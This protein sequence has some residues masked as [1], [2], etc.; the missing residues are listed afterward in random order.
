[1]ECSRE[2]YRKREVEARELERTGSD[3]EKYIF[4]FVILIHKQHATARYI[5]Q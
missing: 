3:K 2:R 4:C 1:M 5:T